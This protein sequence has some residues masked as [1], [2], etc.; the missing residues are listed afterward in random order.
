M[1]EVK[2]FRELRFW[3]PV[4]C[5][6]FQWFNLTTITSSLSFICKIDNLKFK[7]RNV[8]QK[9]MLIL[10]HLLFFDSIRHCTSGEKDE[11]FYLNFNKSFSY[12]TNSLLL[13][14]QTTHGLSELF[15]ALNVFESLETYINRIMVNYIKNSF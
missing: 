14:K 9:E 2:A 15:N 8:L 1:L 6:N 7:T 13:Y 12:F 4:K 5:G 11:I 3:C 10:S